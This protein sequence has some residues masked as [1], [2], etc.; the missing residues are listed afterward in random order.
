MFAL[1]SW[2]EMKLSYKWFTVSEV[3]LSELQLFCQ[4]F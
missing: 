3:L 2:S 1:S 4:N